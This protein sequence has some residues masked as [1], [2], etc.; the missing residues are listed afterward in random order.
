MIL[1]RRFPDAER[2][3]KTPFYPLFP[4]SFLLISIYMFT[5][6]LMDLG[7]GALYGAGVLVVGAVLIGLAHRLRPTRLAPAE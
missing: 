4:V 3:V 5:S 6:S 7:A 2:P 1:R